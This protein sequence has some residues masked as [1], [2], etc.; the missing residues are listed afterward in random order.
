MNIATAALC[1]FCVSLIVECNAYRNP[2]IKTWG[3]REP[4]DYRVFYEVVDKD[5]SWIPFQTTSK[6]VDVSYNPY[7]RRSPNYTYVSIKNF[8]QTS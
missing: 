2:V 3:R 4:Y 8:E 7:Q 6:V 1:V 5:A